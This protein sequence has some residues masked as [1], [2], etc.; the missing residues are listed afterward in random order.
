MAAIAKRV[1]ARKIQAGGSVQLSPVE[2]M[3]LEI[4]DGDQVEVCV[5][6]RE[7]VIRKVGEVPQHDAP[8]AT[9]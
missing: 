8:E 1:R 4:R 6:G 7:I 9:P 3:L 5:E 2:R